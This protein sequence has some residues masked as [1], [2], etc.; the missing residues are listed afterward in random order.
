MAQ[1]ISKP[2]NFINK[3]PLMIEKNMEV[4]YEIKS[5]KIL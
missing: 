4:T 5:I 1:K 2:E 3:F